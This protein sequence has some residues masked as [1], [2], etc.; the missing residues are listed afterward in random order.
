MSACLTWGHNYS[1][2]TVRQ[3]EPRDVATFASAG[4]SRIS[5]QRLPRPCIHAKESKGYNRRVRTVPKITR[6][7]GFRTGLAALVTRMTP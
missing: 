5:L 3:G 2:R 6:S 7:N 4:T 1:I